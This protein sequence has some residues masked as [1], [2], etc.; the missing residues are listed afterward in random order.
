[1]N[2]ATATNRYICSPLN[3]I[4]GKYKLL[5]QLLPLFPEKIDTFVDLFCGGCNVA[6]NS[7]A[8][9]IVCNDNLSYLIDL[10]RTFNEQ[11]TD[12]VLNYVEKRITEYQLSLTNEEGYLSLRKTY[13]SNRYP[14][15]LFVLIA[16]S[17]NHQI[18]FNNSH[19][20]NNPFGRE[21]SSFNPKMKQ[22]LVCFLNRLHQQDVHFHCYNFDKFDTSTL[23]SSDFVYCD[24]PYLITTGTYNDGK[25]GFTGWGEEEEKKLLQLLGDLNSR[26]VRFALSNVLTHKGQTNNLLQQWI[27]ENNFYVTHLKKDYNNSNY[28]VTNRAKTQTD[29]IL[30]TNYQPK[31]TVQQMELELI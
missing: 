24:P 12:S 28:Q 27:L 18:R 30:V 13:N 15:D 3:Y 10:F 31:L 20:F 14:I 21:R 7:K 1:M 6:L 8:K 29:E 23:S 19:D 2:Q 9:K 25:R 22:N 16:Y 5:P 11:T 17:F 4:G 26:G